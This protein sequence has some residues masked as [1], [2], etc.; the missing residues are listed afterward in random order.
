[1]FQYS[2]HYW[3]PIYPSILLLLSLI[4]QGDDQIDQIDELESTYSKDDLPSVSSQ[5]SSLFSFS[6]TVPAHLIVKDNTLMALGKQIKLDYL[7]TVCPIY[8]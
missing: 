8:V 2:S 5:F 4:P 6:S 7:S 3:L 1:M